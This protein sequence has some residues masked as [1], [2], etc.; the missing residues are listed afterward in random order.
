MEYLTL[1]MNMKNIALS[2]YTNYNFN[3]F[4]EIGGRYFG[5][6]SDGIYELDE[7]DDDNDTNIDAFAEF[8]RSDYGLSN[9]KKMR[10]I[11]V[12]YEASGSIQ[13]VTA[14][15]EGSSETYSLSP[16]LAG[17]KQG[18][19]VLWGKRTQKGRYWDMK[20]QNVDG[21]DFSL[22]FIEADFIIGSKK[23]QGS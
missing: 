1:A 5:F 15:D 3:S 9:Q 23:P 13:L 11:I 20:V 4:A 16:T 19:G 21:C 6:N 17:N 12:G 8:T 18:S 22:D 14:A 10:R 7:A 2:Q